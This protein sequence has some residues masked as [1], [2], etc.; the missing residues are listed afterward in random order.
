MK[1]NYK[2][3]WI[4]AAAATAG[5]V[6]FMAGNASAAITQQCGYCHTMHNSQGG[7]A[8]V[9][10]A[11]QGDMGAAASTLNGSLLRWDCIGCHT[12]SNDGTVP[13]VKTTGLTEATYDADQIAATSAAAESLA[14]GN[15]IWEDT[16]DD[17]L[18][19]GHYIGG[20]AD[21]PG[22][23]FVADLTCAGI[24]GCHGDRTATGDFNAVSGA[25]HNNEGLARSAD[26]STVAKSYRFL[27]GIKG[28]ED[29]DW[30]YSF[31][32]TDHNQYY[33]DSRGS[34]PAGTG[35]D[36]TDTATISALCADCHGDF[37]SGATTAGTLNVTAGEWIR[38]PTDFDM[39]TLTT[40]AYYAYNGS[41]ADTANYFV[42]VPLASADVT[43]IISTP[44]VGTAGVAAAV[45]GQAIVTCISCHRAHASPHEDGLRWDYETDCAQ[46]SGTK[47]D[48]G[49]FKCHTDKD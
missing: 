20:S 17:S 36:E 9:N 34:D 19:F 30:E 1:K 43:A 33:G 26:V 49:C 38:H 25:H 2:T 21:A 27:L 5:L 48:C 39:G 18:G 11:P 3:S 40:G 8:F 15:F 44:S 24:T 45:P 37:H 28:Y 14:A 35:D 41:A 42:G 23:S 16:N 32:T 13:Y 10:Q 29:P 22:G 6:L 12:G 46:G 47:A 7:V 31:S 4:T